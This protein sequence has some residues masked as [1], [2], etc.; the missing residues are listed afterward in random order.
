MT[1]NQMKILL[2]WGAGGRGFESRHPDENG[3]ILKVLKLRGFFFVKSFGLQN[4]LGL[5]F[6]QPAKS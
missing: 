3:Q 6:M 5:Q 1:H 4:K 2:S